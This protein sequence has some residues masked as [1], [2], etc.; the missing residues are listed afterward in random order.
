MKV[1]DKDVDFTGENSQVCYKYRVDIPTFSDG[2]EICENSQK[3][4]GMREVVGDTAVI[5]LTSLPVE[6]MVEDEDILEEESIKSQ[7]R[8]QLTMVERLT[9]TVK[10]FENEIKHE[11]SLKV[12]AI[13]LILRIQSALDE[14][15]LFPENNTVDILDIVNMIPDKSTVAWKERSDGGTEIGSCETKTLAQSVT[16]ESNAK[17]QE[18]K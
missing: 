3:S 13:D 10:N 12:P 1:T 8:I 11:K 4:R 17:D 7:P 14:C 16:E 5:P 18:R 9:K 6:G 15:G 2:H